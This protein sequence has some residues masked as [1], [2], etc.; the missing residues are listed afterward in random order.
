MNIWQKKALA[1]GAAAVSFYVVSLIMV[2]TLLMRFVTPD[3]RDAVIIVY[4]LVVIAVTRKLIVWWK[5]F[6]I[7]CIVTLIFIERNHTDLLNRAPDRN[8]VV[9]APRIDFGSIVVSDDWRKLMRRK[10]FFHMPSHFTFMG[11]C[12]SWSWNP[13]DMIQD[14]REESCEPVEYRADLNSLDFQFKP[15]AKASEVYG[16]GFGVFRII[17]EAKL[18]EGTPITDWHFGYHERFG[19]HVRHKKVSIEECRDV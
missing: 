5:V 16:L 19:V 9:Y 11:R 13:L 1:F 3:T 15:H 18:N 10:W 4:A 12:F 6:H 17:M 7:S 14:V 8:G 2:F